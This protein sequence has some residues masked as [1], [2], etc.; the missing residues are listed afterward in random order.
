MELAA[1]IV[2][3]KDQPPHDEHQ[4]TDHFQSIA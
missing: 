1:G 3:K 2:I 4:N